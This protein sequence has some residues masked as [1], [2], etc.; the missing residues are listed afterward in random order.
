[1]VS[2]GVNFTRFAGAWCNGSVLVRPDEKWFLL[3]K[4]TN[5]RSQK[6]F[7]AQWLFDPALTRPT[8]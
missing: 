3:E 7:L 1:M 2:I 4:I 5:R 6:K 8:S